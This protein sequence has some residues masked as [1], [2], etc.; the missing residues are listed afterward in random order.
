MWSTDVLHVFSTMFAEYLVCFGMGLLQEPEW[1]Q[2]VCFYQQVSF[3]VLLPAV[4]VCASSC[5]CMLCKLLLLGR[6]AV[7]AVMY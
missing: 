1:W 7:Y 6:M 5:F 2:G 3:S 4:F